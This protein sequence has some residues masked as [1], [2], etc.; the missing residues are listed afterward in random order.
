MPSEKIL[1]EKQQIVDDL[2]KK[3]QASVAGILVDYKGI[4]VAD[5]TKLRKELREAGVEYTV[6]KNKLLKR[7]LEN[8][9]FGDLTGVLAGTTALATHETDAVIAA[10][11][12][13]KFAENKK[14]FFNLKAGF[15]EG[16]ALDSA[17]VEQLANLPSREE[18]V[19][20]TL[21]GLNAPIS[22][23]VNVLNGNIR[24]LVVALNQIAEKQSA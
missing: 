19:A 4:N 16:K 22:G 23:L 10:K 5:D 17:G 9:D 12:L 1:L 14:N 6:I 18:L 20:Q 21:R 15:V 2:T 13:S 8:A 7:A 11:I 3:I 24:G